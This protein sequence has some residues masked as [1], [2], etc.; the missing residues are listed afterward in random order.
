MG[1]KIPVKDF[2]IILQYVKKNSI[3]FSNLPNY[4]CLI[5]FLSHGMK[6]SKHSYK[7]Y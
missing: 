4:L 6:K 2:P 3:S 7:S 1:N 5:T